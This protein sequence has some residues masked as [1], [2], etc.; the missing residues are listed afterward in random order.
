MIPGLEERIVEGSEED[1]LHVAELVRQLPSLYLSTP[2]TPTC[3]SC[4]RELP[5]QDLMT[6]RV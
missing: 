1:T 4:R 3:N 5:M 2:E 6:Q